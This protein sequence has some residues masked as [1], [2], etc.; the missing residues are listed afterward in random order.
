MWGQEQVI[1]VDGQPLRVVRAGSGPPLLL[2]NGIG[3]AAEMWAPF[4]ARLREHEIIAFDLPGTG[5]SPPLRRLTRMRGLAELVAQLIDALGF[6]RL[7]VLGY[8]FGG[9][10]AQELVRRSPERVERLVLCATSPGV[11]SV[12]PKPLTALLMLTPARYSDPIVA[13]RIVPIIAG[14]RTQRDPTALREHL[15]DR[16]A[17]PPSTRGYL[18]QL[19]AVTGWSSMPW[20]KRIQH[21]TLIMV[22][23]DDPLVSVM[24][25]RYMAATMPRARLRV[26]RGGG[27]LFLLDE[28]DSVVSELGSFLAPGARVSV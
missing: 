25:A 6:R 19:Y 9:I 4:V 8:S 22:G 12:P 1:Q 21:E 14:G 3:A 27:H 13:A 17:R 18:Q 11:I 23:D 15:T 26:V 20:L 24:N 10:V 5:G 28:P 16:L 2:I 7:D